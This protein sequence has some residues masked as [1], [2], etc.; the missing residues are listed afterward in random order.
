MDPIVLAIVTII[1]ILFALAYAFT[2]GSNDS[3]SLVATIIACHAA[4]PRGAVIFASIIGFFGAILGGSAIA[5]TIQSIIGPYGGDVLVLILF[6][7]AFSA[8]AW[9]LMSARL[10]LPSSSTDAMVGGLIGAGIAAG[11]L[12]SIYWG[13]G[14]LL[15]PSMALVGVT[16]IF[17]F[18]LVSVALG[19]LGGYLA[20]KLTRFLLKNA[21]RR[22]NRPIRRAQWVTAGLLAFAHGANDTQK[23]MAIIAL[24]ILGAGYS[25]SATVPD[26]VR[27]ACA[28]GIA[29]GT[30]KGGWSIQKTLG[31]GIYP[32]KPMHSL[33]SQASS[34]VSILASTVMGAPVSTSQ[35]VSSSVI[36]VGAAENARMVRWHVGRQMLLSWFVTMPVCAA[37]AGIIFLVMRTITIGG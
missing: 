8:I 37:I 10:G 15:G 28:L 3:G 25:F 34:A 21:N 31:R 33:D 32:L 4:T 19:F 22:V 16:K 26:W 12:G 29:V 5:L 7:T 30:L 20:L 24:V 1:V 14:E 17:V 36:G 27:I 2:N 11:G 35:V 6:A 23:Q 13:L 18:L 9:N